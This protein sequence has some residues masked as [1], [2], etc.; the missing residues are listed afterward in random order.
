M[1]TEKI[2]QPSNNTEKK[3]HN[4]D[5]LPVSPQIQTRYNNNLKSIAE[6]WSQRFTKE[7]TH[8]MPNRASYFR[9]EN[10]KRT[11][12][13]NS[14]FWIAIGNDIILQKEK[15]MQI[16][17]IPQSKIDEMVWIINS[18][19]RSDMALTRYGKYI[20]IEALVLAYE[21]QYTRTGK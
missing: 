21:K 4:P 9:F 7:T 20:R 17:W 13:L 8:T 15:S 6:V 3:L 11:F 1:S 5:I 14:E 18:N 2:S 12:D 10:G 19:I 16:Q